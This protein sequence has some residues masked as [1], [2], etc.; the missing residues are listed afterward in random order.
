[1]LGLGATA[2]IVSGGTAADVGWWMA[3]TLLIAGI[4][5]GWVITPNTTMTL[6]ASR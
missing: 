6:R 1:V 3:P 2:V 4:G 5:G